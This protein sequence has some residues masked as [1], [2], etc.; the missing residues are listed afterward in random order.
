MRKIDKFIIHCSATKEG[1]DYTVK[2]ID[3]WHREK[4]YAS[5]G[6]HY[7]IYRDGSV[8]EGRPLAQVGAHC[9]G[10]NIDSVGI[11]YIGGL[12]ADGHPKDTRTEEQER[13]LLRLIMELHRKFPK[14]RVY[15][16]RNFASKAC[17]CFDAFQEY[18]DI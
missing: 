6:Y 16:H 12:D 3:R 13:S 7:I 11:C 1:R 15:G 8:H 10:H 5:I 14:A 17:P 2:D 4:G 9:V 18:K